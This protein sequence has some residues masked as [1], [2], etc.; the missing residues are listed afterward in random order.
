ML[1]AEIL[2][3]IQELLPPASAACFV[4]CSQ[5]VLNLLG[6]QSLLSLRSDHQAGERRCLLVR[7]RRDLPHWQPCH[8]CR[9]FHAIQAKSAI[10][11]EMKFVDELAECLRGDDYV[12]RHCY[13]FDTIIGNLQ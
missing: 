6:N 13:E 12:L 7:L 11:T 8:R 1:P 9:T 10:P 5:A 3:M 4:L 2:V